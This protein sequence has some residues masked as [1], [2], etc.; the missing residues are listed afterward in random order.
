MDLAT[1]QFRAGAE[2]CGLWR[3]TAGG[4]EDMTPVLHPS[5]HRIDTFLVNKPLLPWSVQES[6]RARG[7]AHPQ[8]IRSD[9]LPDC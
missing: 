5:R 8:V 4:L 7:M 3:A 6:V 9:Q 2:A 1:E